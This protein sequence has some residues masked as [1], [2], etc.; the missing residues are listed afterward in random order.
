MNTDATGPVWDCNCLYMP[1]LDG[2][3][4]SGYRASPWPVPNT[5]DT[6]MFRGIT[7]L[8]ATIQ[9]ALE[10][11]LDNATE[12]VLTGGSAGGLS[13]FLHSDRVA[14]AI[15]SRNPGIEKIVAAP[16]VGYFLDHSDVD[17]TTG[18]PN[19]PTWKTKEDYTGWMKYIYTMQNLTF[20][21]DGGLTQACQLKHPTQPWL[22]FMSPHM[23]DVIKTPF[24]VFNS[25]YDDWQLN[26]ILKVNPWSGNA[27]RQQA[28][29][30][31]GT[32]FLTDFQPVVQENDKNGAF[33]TSCICHGCPWNDPD[34]LTFNTLNPYQAYANWYTGKTQGMDNFHVDP[35]LPNGG[36]MINSSKCFAYPN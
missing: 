15:R 22:C 28:I 23:Q 11:G 3:S 9:W 21:N 36:G 33:I 2:A 30:Q 7:N 31:Y 16:V 18:T 1:Y 26:E 32:D 4:F 25:K 17:S 29:L 27:T 6:L 12:F 10:H 24:F 8:D 20:G 14:A 19:T 35:R 34:A 13:T 5:N